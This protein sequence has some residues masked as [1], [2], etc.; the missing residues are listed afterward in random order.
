MK[1]I[2]ERFNY[3]YKDI[4]LQ[5]YPSISP[6]SAKHFWNKWEMWS[7]FNFHTQH[8]VTGKISI[9]PA[10]AEIRVPSS[11]VNTPYW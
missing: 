4:K 2:I 9:G 5:L 3:K 8:Y 7:Q 1:R 10:I 6:W 11:S